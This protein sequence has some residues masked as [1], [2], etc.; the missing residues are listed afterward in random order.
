MTTLR[1]QSDSGFDRQLQRLLKK[2]YSKQ[3]YL[4]ALYAIAYHKREELQK[5]KDHALTGNR[6]GLRELHIDKKDWLLVYQIDQ[7]N[8]ILNLVGI[9]T[10]QT[11]FGK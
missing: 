10:H 11:L 4:N 6:R 8:H 7:E 3:L 2:N 1:I 9:G 5:L